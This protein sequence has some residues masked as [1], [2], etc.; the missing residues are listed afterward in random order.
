MTPDLFLAAIG[1]QLPPAPES[2]LLA[3]E[4]ALGC[5][6]PE[7]YRVF[8]ISCNGGYV[9]GK[10]WF[11]GPTPTGQKADAGVHHIGGFRPERHFSLVRAR[12]RYAGRI[13]D[14][15]LWIMDDPF[16]NAICLAIRGQHCGRVY[17]WDHE[18]EPDED[19]DGSIDGAGNLQL[20]AL[21]FT[22]FVAGLHPS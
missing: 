13:P 9:G 6:I 16:G 12:S 19:W 7:D 8:L 5:R 14:D 15:P 11:T 17:F 20:L 10:L 22:A 3:F 18:N 2:D 1:K 21:S 4:Q